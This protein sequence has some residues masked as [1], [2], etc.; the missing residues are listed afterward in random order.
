MDNQLEVSDTITVKETMTSLEIAEVTG[1][2]HSNV[3]RDIRNILE[4]IEDKA[5]FTFELGS[6]LDANGQSR[7]MYS[8]TKKDS[9]LLASGYDANLRAKIINRWE[10]LEIE[11]RN[12]GFEIPKTYSAALMLAAKQAEEIEN[13]QK[14]L[15]IKETQIAEL[16]PKATYYDSILASKSAECVTKFAKADYGISAQAMNKLL[17][18]FGI[19]YKVG[20]T[21]LP[22]IQFAKCGYTQTETIPI[23][24][25]HGEE[26]KLQTKWTQKGR[27]F[28][29]EQMKKHGYLPIIEQN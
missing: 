9:I 27:L 1:R 19:Q 5:Q 26:S 4:Q 17:H 23:K 2:Q 8:L 25:N 7:P 11:K 14:Q 29:Y 20:E 28:I 24:T 6:Y 3:L 16:K 10:Q 21:W 18:E 13:Q 15:E 12:G 22:Y